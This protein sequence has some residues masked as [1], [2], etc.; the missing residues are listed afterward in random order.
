[1]PATSE[2]DYE[3]L[4]R[5]IGLFYA[6][7]KAKPH[8]RPESHPLAALEELEKKSRSQ[9]K[10][11]L[12]MAINEC[13]EDSSEWSPEAVAVA[14]KRF[15]LNGSP[16]LSEI[17]VRYSRTY[18][19]VLKRGRIR[20]LKEYYLVKGILDGGGIEPGAGEAQELA[21]MLTDF[22]NRVPPGSENDR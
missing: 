4:K 21:S 2:P 17:R 16:T 22:E 19:E 18:L 10:R 7:Y 13:I 9:A 1:M 15:L 12:E 3:G 8:H 20:S 11:G 14:D 6:W 5:F